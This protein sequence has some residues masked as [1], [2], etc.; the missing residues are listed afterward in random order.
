MFDWLKKI[1]NNRK[2]KLMAVLSLI[3]KALGLPF[4]L[5]IKSKKW[6]K[7]F[8]QEKK[9]I[10]QLTSGR[11]NF[12]RFCQDSKRLLLDFFIP[13]RG[14]NFKPKSLRPKSL[15]SYTAIAI[16][17][18]IIVI[19]FLF[20]YYP[21]PAQLSA[22]ISSN[23]INLINNS[24]KEVGLDPLVDNSILDKYAYAKGQDMLN[25][26]YFAHDTPE[27]RRP[28][29]WINR[30]EYDYIYAGENL[31]MDFITAEAVHDAFMK[32][33]THQRN[34]LNSK[35]KEIGMAVLN[36]EFNGKKTILLVQFFGTQRKDLS[37]LVAV[38]P[39]VEKVDLKKIDEKASES[40]SN[41]AS[42]AGEQLVLEL[43]A[44]TPPL[45]DT[46]T[47]QIVIAVKSQ[48]GG[49]KTLVDQIIY[50]SNIFFLAFL[51]F[52]LI[53]LG[54]N[55]LIKIKIQH[56]SVIFQSLA[57]IALILAMSLVKLHF[58]EQINSTLL[59]L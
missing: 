52:L 12:S 32:S 7:L 18:K 43:V 13:Y 4:L 51:I 19:I 33:P 48:D 25:R 6:Q 36:G 30:A 27:G 2:T 16:L 34:I 17:T 56:P 59:I 50:Y 39:L 47:S 20:S 37:G 22:I 44:P 41:A 11:Q 40:K 21:S 45:N 23:I 10:R 58:I 8:R 26:D 14:N 55:I 53:S 57:V 38:P 29:Q 35:Y 15:A 9:E 54:L 28:W 46:E 42:I 1:L 24:R 31:A 49:T 5:F 3:F